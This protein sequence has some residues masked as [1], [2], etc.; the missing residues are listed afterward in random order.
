MQS[1]LIEDGYIVLPWKQLHII[2]SAC[3]C[4]H[5]S[6]TKTFACTMLFNDMMI[7]EWQK[8]ALECCWS[9]YRQLKYVMRNKSRH[10][11]TIG[12]TGEQNKVLLSRKKWQELL[13]WGNDTLSVFS[14][15]Y[16]KCIGLHAHPVHV[17][18]IASFK[19]WTWRMAS[20]HTKIKLT[21]S[22]DI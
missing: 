10:R 6:F 1:V 5:S 15:R 19:C 22:C 11:L 2:G 8:F 3:K 7:N 20:L 9:P 21:Y 13:I 16:I 14:H 17:S 18:Y 12:E 4:L